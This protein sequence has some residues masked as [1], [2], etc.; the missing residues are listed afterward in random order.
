MAQSLGRTA[1]LL[2]LSA[3]WRDPSVR[4]TA[5]CVEALEGAE[6]VSITYRAFRAGDACTRA[7]TVERPASYWWEWARQEC[8]GDVGFEGQERSLADGSCVWFEYTADYGALEDP[9]LRPCWA[10]LPCCDPPPRCSAE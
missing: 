4:D 5:A 8:I 1:L 10:N 2:L 9:W 7:V 3:C 6:T